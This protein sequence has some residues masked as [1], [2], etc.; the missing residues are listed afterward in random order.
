V[1]K[2]T[3]TKQAQEEYHKKEYLE[4]TQSEGGN[5]KWLQIDECPKSEQNLWNLSNRPPGSLL[6][7]H[8][9]LGKHP[10]RDKEK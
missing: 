4:N 1:P 6:E 7:C 5:T 3:T 8:T 9:S 2:P 10:I